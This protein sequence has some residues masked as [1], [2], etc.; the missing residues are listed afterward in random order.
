[1]LNLLLGT[2]DGAATYLWGSGKLFIVTG[3]TLCVL[4]ALFFYKQ[5]SRLA[6]YYGQVCLTEALDGNPLA[7]RELRKLLQE[8]DAWDTWIPY[9]WGFTALMTGF[10][11]YLLAMFVT[12]AAPR[13][14]P[15]FSDP[16]YKATREV[17]WGSLVVVG[18]TGTAILQR[19]VLTTQRFEEEPWASFWY[20]RIGRS[21]KK[22]PHCGVFTRLRP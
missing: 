17:V 19:L 5:R 1:A 7:P 21:K 10:L 15:S 6:W 11:F 2:K 22:L 8:A 16:H 20:D 12:Y 4:A 9:S 18:A 13:F 14:W 3:S